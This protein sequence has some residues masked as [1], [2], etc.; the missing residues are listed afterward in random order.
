MLKIKLLFL[1]LFFLILIFFFNNSLQEKFNRLSF[2]PFSKNSISINK[3]NNLIKNIK[4]EKKIHN[5]YKPY[6]LVLKTNYKYI[7]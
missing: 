4:L 2:I 1:I 3:Y 6:N 7:K 5:K